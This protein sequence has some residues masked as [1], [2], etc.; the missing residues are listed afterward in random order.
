MMD[1]ACPFCHTRAP[2][3]AF[4]ADG[5]ARR[6]LAQALRCTA[7]P[8]T[9][10]LGYLD[11]HRPAQRS[12]SWARAERLLAELAE[13]MERGAVRRKGRDWPV[14]AAMWREGLRVV[15]ERHGAGDV[16]QLRDHAYLFEVL[17]GLSARAES[18]EERRAE[19]ERRRRPRH[20]NPAQ[21]AADVVGRALDAMEERAGAAARLGHRG[22][23]DDATVRA[24]LDGATDA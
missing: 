2:L 18:A 3:A 4:L 24:F 19:E 11:A 16:R 13:A 17:V 1:A 8:A 20:E 6:A 21:R 23:W 12:L 9:L 22:P 15:V 7:A 14:D 5:A 10:V